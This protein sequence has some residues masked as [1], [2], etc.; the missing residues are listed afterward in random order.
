VTTRDLV[1]HMACSADTAACLFSLGILQTPPTTQS[2]WES[3]RHRSRWES[4]KLQSH[5]KSCKHH[6]QLSLMGNLANVTH[7]SV[8]LGILQASP[9]TQSHW[10]SCKRYPRLSLVGNPADVTHNSVSLQMHLKSRRTSCS[11]YQTG[12]DPF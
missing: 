5:W 11:R 8:S 2:H 7:N 4:C 3:C 9:T 6:P 12:T 1:G 10:E